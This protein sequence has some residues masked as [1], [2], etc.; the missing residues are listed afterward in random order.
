MKAANAIG[1][2]R[3]SI[4]KNH[5]ANRLRAASPTKPPPRKGKARRP[6]DLPTLIATATEEVT[7]NKTTIQN[8]GTFSRPFLGLKTNASVS[9]VKS[10][11]DHKARLSPA[12][13]EATPAYVSWDFKSDERDKVEIKKPVG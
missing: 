12:A 1:A 2:K 7:I 6:P 13:T 9:K 10:P 4:A 8:F 11:A 3:I 5:D